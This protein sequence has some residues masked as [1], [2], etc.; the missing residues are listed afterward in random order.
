[1]AKPWKLLT[2]PVHLAKRMVWSLRAGPPSDADEAWA[3]SRLLDGERGL[4]D[5]MNDLDRHHSIIVA[6][7]F[8]G[9]RP[10]ATR[11]EVAGALLHDVGKI[12]C[13]LG[14]FGRVVAS[15]VGPITPTFRTYHDHERLGAEL[16]ADVGSDP[17]TVALIAEPSEALEQADY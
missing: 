1:M 6:R 3:R 11:A 7:R 4:W 16:A 17:V 15:V 10:G 2:E 13:E 9:A 8:L 14:T 12:L 5:R